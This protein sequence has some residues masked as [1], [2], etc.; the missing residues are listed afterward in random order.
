MSLRTSDDAPDGAKPGGAESD[1][2]V[3]SSVATPVKRMNDVSSGLER[4]TGTGSL[5]PGTR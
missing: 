1:C 2:P 5:D 3:R 4:S